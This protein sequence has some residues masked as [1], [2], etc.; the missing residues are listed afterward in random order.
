MCCRSTKS[1]QP[2]RFRRT[3]Y[4]VSPSIIQHGHMVEDLAPGAA[5]LCAQTFR[6]KVFSFANLSSGRVNGENPAW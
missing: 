4:S 5:L 1:C 2:Q 3:G 6:T